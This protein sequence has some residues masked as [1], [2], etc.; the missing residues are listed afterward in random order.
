MFTELKLF[1]LMEGPLF[2]FALFPLFQTDWVFLSHWN[3]C[4]PKPSWHDD[5][6]NLAECTDS[7]GVVSRAL[8]NS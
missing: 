6:T 8:D 5:E 2:I 3:K 4:R 7:N 1:S